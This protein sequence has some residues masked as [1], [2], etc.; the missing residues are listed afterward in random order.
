MR[1]ERAQVIITIGF[2]ITIALIIIT[3]MLSDIIFAGSI[4]SQSS[5]ETT[6]QDIIQL[7][8]LTQAEVEKAIANANEGGTPNNTT[9]YTYISN[10]SQAAKL[11]YASRGQAVNVS[12]ID[13]TIGF[14]GNTT[15]G[16][17][18][19]EP[20]TFEVGS[21]I[22]P[23]DNNQSNFSQLRAYG[24]VYRILN[25]IDEADDFNKSL[26]DGINTDLPWNIHVHWLFQQANDTSNS[27]GNY[28]MRAYT[29]NVSTGVTMVRRYAGGPFLVD[30][31]DIDAAKA[32]AIIQAASE[33][34]IA[35]HIL[36]TTATFNTGVLM[37]PPKWAFD[38]NFVK[39]LARD[40]GIGVDPVNYPN[41][42]PPNW[43]E[44]LD[45]PTSTY[46]IKDKN[47]VT[48]PAWIDVELSPNCVKAAFGCALTCAKGCWFEAGKLNDTYDALLMDHPGFDFDGSTTE[49][50]EPI[51][52]FVEGGGYV[53]VQCGPPTWNSGDKLDSAVNS[54]KGN[55]YGFIGVDKSGS[56][57]QP[58]RWSLTNNSSLSFGQVYSTDGKVAAG[59]GGSG[60]SYQLRAITNPS[61]EVISYYD[62]AGGVSNRFDTNDYIG[63]IQAH[64][65]SDGSGGVVRY[66]VGHNQEKS[67][68]GANPPPPDVQKVRLAINQAFYG[69]LG[70]TNVNAITAAN[71]TI[72]FTDA[73]TTFN[74]TISV[75]S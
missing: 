20:N 51:V 72:T 64:F 30:I 38:Q 24:L 11:I 34:G 32:A 45:Q 42:Y 5:M 46:L 16:D 65:P 3:L 6:K 14:A 57:P 60:P 36:N 54:I 56:D 1:D 49:V 67:S 53:G 62:K 28:S 26:T 27:T 9:F 2:L 68:T 29:T 40:A 12:I 75:Q 58:N 61:Y 70:R 31:S 59:A 39:Y 73:T 74:S 35:I 48:A 10:F 66:L 69:V 15:G 19:V 4:S 37:R 47:G 41:D 33:M 63:M 22:I 71:V 52:E 50:T 43:P 7:L 8:T 55:G 17:V 21:L 23:M 18:M 25:E 44:G 13:I